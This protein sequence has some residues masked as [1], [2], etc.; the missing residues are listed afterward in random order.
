MMIPLGG[1]FTEQDLKDAIS[2]GLPAWFKLVGIVLTLA[3]AVPTLYLLYSPIQLVVSGRVSLEP[4]LLLATFLPLLLALPMLAGVVYLFWIYPTRQVRRFAESPLC[5]GPVT[6]VVMD[7]TLVLRSG[8]AE[9]TLR[10][11]TLVGYKM[12]DDIVLLY[13]NKTA[14]QLV[15]RSLFASDEDWQR[16]RDHVRATVRK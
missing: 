7:D 6:G 9:A 2:L 5:R 3:F 14:A 10:W 8:G 12:S 13:E 16:F 4:V 15:S 1:E 11:D